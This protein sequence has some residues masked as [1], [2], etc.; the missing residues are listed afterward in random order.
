MN[1]PTIKKSPL[2]RLGRIVLKTVLFIIALFIVVVLLILTPPVQ[3]FLRKKAVTYLENKLHTKVQVGRIYIGLPKKIVVEDVYLEDQKKDT[4]L[5]AGSVKMDMAILKLIFKQKLEINSVKLD[6][7]TALVN[8]Q[9][10]D[11]SFNYQ[12]I[13]DAFSPAPNP[14]PSKPTDTTSSFI[15]INSVVLNKARLVYDDVVTGTKADAW[16]DHFDTKVNKYD[17]EHLLIDIPY[18]NL[19]GLM[20]HFRQI[21]PLEVPNA[22]PDSNEVQTTSINPQITLGKVSITK[23]NLG[24]TNDIDA[25]YT[26][27]DIGSLLVELKKINFAEQ[28]ID[29]DDIILENTTSAFRMGKKEAAKKVIK[30]VGKKIDSSLEKGWCIRVA[31]FN[32]GNNN[33]QF[34]DENQPRQKTGMDYSHIKTTPFNLEANDFLFCDDSIAAKIQKASFKEQSGFELQEL[35]T[36]FLFSDNE[37]YLHNLY[38]KTPGTELKRNAYIRYAS[39]DA[40]EKDIAN[41]WLDLDLDHSKVLVSDVLTFAPQLKQSPAFAYPGATWYINTRITGRVSDLRIDEF[42]VQGLNDTKADLHGTISGLPNM[43]HFSANLVINNISSSRRDIDRFI[44]KG[45]IPS[46]ITVPSRI[47]ISGSMRGNANDLN[48]SLSARTDLGDAIVKGKFGYLGNTQKMKYDALVQTRFLDLGT[49]LQD[50]QTLGKVTAT[51]NVNG[52]GL[53]PKTANLAVKGKVHS[54]VLNQYNYKDLDINAALVKQQATVDASMADPNIHFALNASAD[55]SKDHPDFHISGMIDSIRTQPLHLTPDP[56]V[57][58]GKVEGNFTS[59]DPDDLVGNLFLTQNVFVQDKER[60]QLD[61]VQ[62]IAARTDS[63]HS[64]QLTSDI[65]V[66]KLQGNYRVTQLGVILQQA[67]QP[68]F[69]IQSA[70]YGAAPVRR[71]Q[72]YDFTLNANV[73]NSAPLKVFL[74][75]LERMDSLT[76]NSHFSNTNGWNATVTAPILDYG[77]NRI[78]QLNLKAGTNADSANVT[79]ALHAGQITTAGGM[80]LY[81]TSLNASIA[82]NKVNFAVDTRDRSDRSRYNF[83]GVFEQP[84]PDNYVFSFAPEGL[85]LNY[86]RWTVPANNKLTITPQNLLASNFVLSRNGQ[87]ISINSLSQNANS[88]LEVKFDNFRLATVTAFVQSDS[89]LVDGRL[90][91]TVSFADIMHDPIF[92]GDLTINDLSIKNDTAGNAVI[93]ISNTSEDVYSATATLTGRGNDVRLEGKYFMRGN[94]ASTYN[95]NLDIVA[96]PMKTIEAFTTGAIRNASGYANGKFSVTGTMQKP[97]INGD[98]NFDNAAFTVSTLGNHFRIDKEKIEINDRGV[99]FN[100]FQIR[101]SLNNTLVLNGTAETS[102]FSDYKFDF[103]VRANDFQALNS[104]KQD[105][106][107]YY[108]QLFFNSNVRVTGTDKTPIVDG[109]IT[110]NEKTK[111]T[112]VLPQSEPGIVEREGVI[113]FVDKDA[114]GADTLFLSSAYDSLNTTALRGLDL[115]A[116]I[117][118]NKG[119]DFS[120]IIDEGNGDF[121]NVKGEALLTAGIDPSGKLTLAGS[122]EIEEGAYE[123]TFNFI[124]RKFIIDKGSKIV[125]LGEPTDADVDVTATYIANV[126]PLDLVKNQLDDNIAITQ[127]NTYLQKIPFDINLK[128]EGKL[129]KPEISFDILLPEDKSYRVSGDILTNVRNKLDILRQEPGEMNKQVF[130]VLLLNRFIGENPFN[131]STSDLNANTLARQSVSK[132]LTEQLNRLAG[133]LIEGVDLNFDVISSDDYTSGERR[134]RT[135]LNIG[136]SKQLLNDRLS[137]SVGSNFELQ[138]PQN[139]TQ[140]TNNIAG[141]LA[142]DYRVSKD[143]RYL[144]RAYRKNE[145]EGIIDGYIIETGVS[146]I[147]TVDYNRFRQIFLSKEQRQKRREVRRANREI[148]RETMD[149]TIIQSEQRP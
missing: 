14:S 33:L 141:N 137:V 40:L 140:K 95:M 87:Q 105:N 74:P 61:T 96:L 80:T 114:P 48:T 79:T 10:S 32:S 83:S 19:N 18:I 85:L 43:D 133:D 111:M 144:L 76:L 82:N 39:L 69:S 107:L 90:N 34:D 91:G 122:Y 100:N 147:I 22:L 5:A 97:K 35:T 21:K 2:R 68:Y 29:F 24:Y 139:S 126:A 136:L 78:R 134:D 112:I 41:L 149:S 27:A 117:E 119:A 132:L 143:G 77:G 75:Q 12:F 70:S 65:A 81:N 49:I 124:R 125:W 72:P 58:H 38:L 1:Q 17:A 73:I 84:Q 121:L 51:F 37:A 118:V 127:R 116:N 109:N 30:E 63:G 42:Q 104:T 59:A 60:I 103:T 28:E 135:D 86:E 110:V 92:K 55:I 46:N 101:D 129:L 53:D 145:Y 31:S 64:I 15:S 23:S 16:I 36:D 146:F 89:T 88:P 120:L 115:T 66:A 62:V 148:R 99:R 8:R 54:A 26:T 98:L 3:N 94:G 20:A 123:I 142:L 7:I 25:L 44:P 13:V 50:K 93:H 102:N 128:M 106:N 130:A 9:G 131:S 57:Y 11:T 67:I 47:S 108:G 56:F 138:G 6:N 45:T 4:L 52:T 113:E 71:S